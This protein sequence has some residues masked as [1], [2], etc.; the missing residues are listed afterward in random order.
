MSNTIVIFI[1]A[2]TTGTGMLAL[3]K[4]TALGYQPFFFTNKPQRYRGLEETGS[5]VITCNTNDVEQLKHV[6]ETTVDRS[7][8]AGIMTTSEFYLETVAYLASCFEL[9]GNSLNSMKNVRNKYFTRQQLATSKVKQPHFYALKHRTQI[10]E[11]L[12]K[13]GLPC[14]VKPVD[15]SGSNNVLYCETLQQVE[16]QVQHIL[17]TTYNVRGQ[18]NASVVLIEQFVAGDEYSVEMLS[19]QGETMVLGITK[20]YVSGFPYFV[21]AGHQFP[22]TLALEQERHMIETVRQAI[23]AVGIENGAT[24]TEVKWT[25]EGCS[26]IEMNGRMAGGMIPELIHHTTGV[27]VL[28]QQIRCFLQGPT[29]HALRSNGVAG[30]RFI[31]PNQTGTLVSVKGVE[32]VEQMEGVKQ[33]VVTA[34]LGKDIRTPQNA[35]DRIGY[36]I[37]HTDTAS[38]TTACLEK[39]VNSIQMEVNPIQV[40]VKMK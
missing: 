4:V 20:K 9:C 32:A 39:A 36:I 8:I 17:S 10:N 11:A 3:K 33:V 5:R 21:E 6:V 31:Q 13:I 34:K 12:D 35:Y 24:H 30:I 22:A 18:Q 2:N 16:K 14:I 37:A 29:A 7:H 26:I 38:E 27:D 23:D 1:E 25:E 19:W 40:G 15:D 28:E